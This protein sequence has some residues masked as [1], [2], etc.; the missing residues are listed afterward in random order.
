MSTTIIPLVAWSQTNTTIRLKVEIHHATNVNIQLHKNNTI[1]LYSETEL[2]TNKSYNLNIELYDNVNN[3]HYTIKPLYVSITLNKTKG[4]DD[5]KWPRLIKSTER[6]NKIK[7]DWD[8]QTAIDE[9][10]NTD[11]SIQ[12]QPISD[13]EYAEREYQQKIRQQTSSSNIDTSKTTAATNKSKQ[14]RNSNIKLYKTIYLVSYNII[15]VTCWFILLLTQQL[16]LSFHGL[17]YTTYYEFWSDNS[18]IAIICQILSSIETINIMLGLMNVNLFTSIAFH[19][20]RNIILLL[21]YILHNKP[22][23][24]YHS[25]VFILFLCWSI[26]DI[27]RYVYYT[28]N[29]IQDIPGLDKSIFASSLQQCR[30][31]RLLVPL[32]IFP[33]GAIS[34]LV[35]L[36]NSAWTSQLNNDGIHIVM[37]LYTALVYCVG[38]PKLYKQMWRSW[39]K[40]KV[41]QRIS[42]SNSYVQPVHRG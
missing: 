28:I 35:I 22:T 32:F 40:Y 34:E 24:V 13:A 8:T 29:S 15:V 36:Y 20:G 42:N 9:E 12:H 37:L 19:T 41:E 10:Y 25:S 27:T 16:L 5:N 30:R 2:Y 14:V 1:T 6:N 39:N 17:S 26:G 33:L 23:V 38:V 31:L 21:L 4:S 3:I 7:I 18:N 11:N